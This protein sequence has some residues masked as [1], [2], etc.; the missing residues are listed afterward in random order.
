MGEEKYKSSRY[1]I[2]TKKN[3]EL[4]LVN[5]FSSSVLKISDGQKD[6]I[7]R[8]ISNPNLFL[9]D[10][11]HKHHF[12]ILVS[13][14]FLIDETIDEIKQMEFL[15]KASYFNNET[16]RFT[17]LPTLKCNFECPYCFEDGNKRIKWSNEDV[18][19]L[20]LF[21]KKQFKNKKKISIALFGGEPLIEWEK[22]KELFEYITKLKKKYNF[23][24]SNSIA[25]NGYLL[26]D[27]KIKFLVNDFDFNSFQ[28]TIDGCK[29]TH[30]TTRC[31]KNG[32]P[33]FKKIVENIKSLIRYKNQHKKEVFINIRVNLLNN[34][35]EEVNEFLNSEFSSNERDSINIYFR[36]VYNT[37][38]FNT[39]NSNSENLAEFFEIARSLKY[40]VTDDITLKYRY[41][42]CEGDGFTKQFQI[43]PDLSLWKCAHDTS[44]EVAN[45][46]FI[47][48]D[49]GIN[50]DYS[51]L[52]KWSRNNPFDD[53][54]CKNCIYLPICWGGCPLNYLKTGE[55][56]CFYEKGFNVVDLFF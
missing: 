9:D 19:I 39:K 48:N 55:R 5:T 33:T 16:L 38:H 31:L 14:N 37:N 22:V 43:Q 30:D 25:T 17:L 47:E 21:V 15:Y 41:L 4:F 35:L 18:Q 28:I 20:K 7:E 42:A 46:G 40:K 51:K 32:K 34:T 12:S 11:K 44:C 54:K 52:E 23:E 53:Q 3:D 29:R 49:G 27:M 6:F 2:F 8:L 10:K 45:F 1:T 24:L 13:N 26:N 36:P 56:S 50:I